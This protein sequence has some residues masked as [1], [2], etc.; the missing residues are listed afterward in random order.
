[1]KTPMTFG[2]VTEADSKKEGAISDLAEAA[3]NELDNI[4]PESVRSAIAQAKTSLA[5]A[6]TFLEK[7][8][9][10]F[11][12]LYDVV[13]NTWAG[14]QQYQPLQYS[15][16]FIGLLMIFFGGTFGAT[17]AAVETFH[18]LAYE[19]TKEA[20]TVLYKQYQIA[21]DAANKDEDQHALSVGDRREAELRRRALLIFKSVDPN[22]I[23]RASSAIWSGCFGV[24][25]ALRVKFAHAVSLG[26]SI[27]NMTTGLFHRYGEPHLI[28]ML[29]ESLHKWVPFISNYLCRSFAVSLAWTFQIIIVA[30]HAALRG[31]NLFVTGV[32]DLLVGKGFM[33]RASLP[34]RESARWNTIVYVVAAVGFYY[35]AKSGFSVPFPLNL[36]LW[37]ISLVEFT[38]KLIVGTYGI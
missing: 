38:L 14:A 12:K 2:Q 17:I 13:V 22:K 29:P 27:G 31:S 1:M 19:D 4:A 18:H 15:S 6:S 21:D 25:C 20:L 32:V 16:V 10:K 24:V 34:P 7:Q 37:P 30:F 23:S 36:F 11:L 3:L 35:Q 28:A 8:M 5:P 33:K 9:P 26:L